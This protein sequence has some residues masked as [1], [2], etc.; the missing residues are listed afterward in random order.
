MTPCPFGTTGDGTDVSP[1][2]ANLMM[3][4]R[5]SPKNAGKHGLS[6]ELHQNGFSLV[7]SQNF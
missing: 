5:N 7:H 4:F 3:P 1:V 2:S 6:S